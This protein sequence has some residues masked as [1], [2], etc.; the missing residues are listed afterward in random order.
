[1]DVRRFKNTEAYLPCLD[2]LVR[3]AREV[4]RLGSWVRDRAKPAV[5]ARS[6]ARL[7]RT[8]A[9]LSAETRRVTHPVQ[10]LGPGTASVDP[11]S[12]DC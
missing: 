4:A 12:G 7:N 5:S 6:A 9:W 2:T 1:M 3:L 8:R 11:G 10:T